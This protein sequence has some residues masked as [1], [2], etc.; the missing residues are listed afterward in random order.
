MLGEWKRVILT[1]TFKFEVIEGEDARYFK[2]LS[3]R[4]AAGANFKAMRLS[5]LQTVLDVT[6]FI[7]RKERVNE[8]LT[9]AAAANFFALD[10]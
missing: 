4:Q 6:G 10:P 3:Q 2:Q 8:K 5:A 1:T 7:Q 9:A